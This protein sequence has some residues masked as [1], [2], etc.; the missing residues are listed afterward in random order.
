M[1]LGWCWANTLTI[2]PK[3]RF[4]AQ[5]EDTDLIYSNPQNPINLTNPTS[6][7]FLNHHY[8]FNS[9]MNFLLSLLFK[10]QI[11]VICIRE[12]ITKSVTNSI[13]AQIKSLSN[14]KAI[15]IVIDSDK[16]EPVQAEKLVNTIRHLSQR[17]SV[18]VY[19]FVEAR[20]T[21]GIIRHT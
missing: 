1:G 10:P 5:R 8:K 4:I 21:G 17:H 14:I 13:E 2:R 9:P 6:A 15:A 7:I 18:P 20:C 11:P 16:G 3:P 12:S 19:S